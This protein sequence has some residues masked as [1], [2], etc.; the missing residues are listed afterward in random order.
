MDRQAAFSGTAEIRAP[1]RFDAEALAAYLEDHV[2]GFAGPLTVTLTS[3]VVEPNAPDP[4]AM[5]QRERYDPAVEGAVIVKLKVFD[6]PGPIDS[7]GAS[8][9]RFT[10]H[11]RLSIGPRELSRKPP[12]SV[13][14]VV[15][16]FL[17]VTDTDVLCPA[18]IVEGML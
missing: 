9:I 8:A 12:P 4:L 3:D 17:I 1:H 2:E 5:L 13:H 7:P 11:V 15:P 18:V 10:P 6:C 14:V 16:E